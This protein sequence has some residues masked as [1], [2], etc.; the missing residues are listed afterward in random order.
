M[1][2]SFAFTGGVVLNLL[3]LVLFNLM[4]NATERHEL[5]CWWQRDARPWGGY[6]QIERL[7]CPR[8]GFKS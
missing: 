1:E 5:C 4:V 7:A 2:S 6:F 8:V 3:C